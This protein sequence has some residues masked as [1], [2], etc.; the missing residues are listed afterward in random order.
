MNDPIADGCHKTSIFAHVNNDRM[1]WNDLNGMHFEA[2]ERVIELLQCSY[3]PRS[4][5]EIRREHCSTPALLDELL[6][7]GLP[8]PAAL[9]ESS[10]F[11]PRRVVLEFV[12]HCNASCPV[13]SP[14]GFRKDRRFHG[15]RSIQHR[16]HALAPVQP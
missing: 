10:V 13:L 16:A 14:V 11:Y 1:L 9:D 4:L 12:R 6:K 15:R 8:V 3:E 7:T 2:D 5:V